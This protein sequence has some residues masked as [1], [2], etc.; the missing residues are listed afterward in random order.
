MKKSF[1]GGARKGAGRPTTG[2]QPTRSVAMSAADWARFDG[3]AA[4]LGMARG[5]AVVWLLDQVS[6][7]VR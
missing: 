3:L 6:I 1:H 2:R 4:R 5:Q 7:D